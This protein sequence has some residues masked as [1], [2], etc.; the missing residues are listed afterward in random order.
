M[1]LAIVP[2]LRA[3][4][5]S[6]A[7]FPGDLPAVLPHEVTVAGDGGLNA[8]YRCPVC[9]RV[10]VTGWDAEAAGWPGERRQAA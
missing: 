8:S 3:A 2:D 5:L 10:W 4:C 7:H 1:T 9:G 6:L